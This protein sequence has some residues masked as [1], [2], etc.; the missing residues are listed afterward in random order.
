MAIRCYGT[1][2]EPLFGHR[3]LLWGVT[4]AEPEGFI[5]RSEPP[6]RDDAPCHS[7]VRY[8]RQ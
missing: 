8:G 5:A 4:L 6:P 2:H 1:P 7:G 3:S